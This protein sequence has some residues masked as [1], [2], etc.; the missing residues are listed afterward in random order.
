MQLMPFFLL[1]GL[2]LL[3]TFKLSPS[4]GSFSPGWV[5]FS[6]HRGI[7]ITIWIPYIWTELS[8][9]IKVSKCS[10]GYELVLVACLSGW[11]CLYIHINKGLYMYRYIYTKC[12]K[13]SF[14]ILLEFGI[15][16]SNRTGIVSAS[17]SHINLQGDLGRNHICNGA[18]WYWFTSPPGVWRFL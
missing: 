8:K 12:L 7:S 11:V 6:N 10:L 17:W 13:E 2:L 4:S 16:M 15:R 3:N 18:Q 1:T 14:K 5:Q 9:G